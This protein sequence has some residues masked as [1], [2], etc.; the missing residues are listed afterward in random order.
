MKK[1]KQIDKADLALQEAMDRTLSQ[2]TI[3]E[4]FKENEWRKQT[5]PK[6]EE[7][8]EQLSKSKHLEVI[9]NRMIEVHKENPNTDY[10]I[11]LKNIIQEE[12]ETEERFKDY[13]YYNQHKN[14]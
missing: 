4:V 10:M 14:K 13:L 6:I 9:L 2:I 7:T 8:C 5:N 11:K 3:P 12:K 1:K